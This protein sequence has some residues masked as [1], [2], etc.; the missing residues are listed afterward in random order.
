MS[1]VINKSEN[2]RPVTESIA[3]IYFCLLWGCN[4]NQRQRGKMMVWGL[5][6]TDDNFGGQKRRTGISSCCV[7][8]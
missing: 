2:V 7:L 4:N 3:A 5:G 1:R 8:K 6:N